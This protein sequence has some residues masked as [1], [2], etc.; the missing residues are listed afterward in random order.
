MGVWNVQRTYALLWALPS[1]NRSE[2]STDTT[3]STLIPAKSSPRYKEIF[4]S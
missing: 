2:A 3:E 4:A 1:S